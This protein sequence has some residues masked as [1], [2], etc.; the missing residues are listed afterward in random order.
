MN[1]Q[2]M[3]GVKIDPENKLAVPR[4]CPACGARLTSQTV[5]CEYCGSSTLPVA[6]SLSQREEVRL[7]AHELNAQLETKSHLLNQKFKRKLW[8]GLVSYIL[9]GIFLQFALRLTPQWVI[10]IPILCAAITFLILRKLYQAARA[11]AFITIY[12]E[13]LESQISKFIH[14][15]S[16][17]RWQFD[18]LADDVLDQSALLHLFLAGKS[19]TRKNP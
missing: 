7:L 2:D 8:I 6:F 18:N 10:A 13:T 19:T 16:I 11:S 9:L 5:T 15:K 14:L 4:K 1:A 17:P 3:P 12:F